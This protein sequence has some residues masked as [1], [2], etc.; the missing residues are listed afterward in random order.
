M[1]E[2]TRGETAGPRKRVMV[3][4][5]RVLQHAQEALE[6]ERRAIEC[7]AARLDHRLVRAVEM[8]LAMRG[9][10]IVCG[11]G[12]SGAIGR[13]LAA[14]FASTGTPA[15]FMHAAEAV[16]GDLGMIDAED[17]AVL[18]TNSGET[19]E[20]VRILPIIKRRG[21]GTIAICGNE[22]STVARAAD[23]L[24][25]AS[26]EREAC[27]L[28][29]A[30]TSSA[31]AELA[32]GDALAMALMAARGFSAED[33]GATH[34]GGQLG[35]RVLLTVEDVMHGGE[36]NPAVG[37][38]ATVEE[39]LLAMTNA[40]VRGAVCIVDDDG[41]L[42]GLFTDGDFRRVVQE[43]S[44]RNALMARSIAEVMTDEPT[45][46]RVG[47]L[48]YEALNVMDEREFDNLPVVDD[49]GRAVG[50]LDIQDLMKAGLV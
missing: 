18:I 9:R 8:L 36:S 13:K 34:P 6:L 44:D 25:D 15:Y 48:A 14:T 1:S 21:A 42:R 32:L 3:D 2:V 22:N 5:A 31:I 41:M 46:V 7:V 20:I 4:A 30:P 43:E 33:F 37:L 10:V 50:M 28:N 11:I 45:T 47:T 40:A 27:P 16:H 29:L 26:V 35:K 19:D 12:K 39:A 49:D 23:V 38:D 24:L 17:I